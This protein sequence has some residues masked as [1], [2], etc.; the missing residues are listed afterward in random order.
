MSKVSVSRFIA[1]CA[2]LAACADTNPTVTAPGARAALDEAAADGIGFI[3]DGPLDVVFGAEAAATQMAASVQAATGG[4]AS[5]HV[6]FNSGLPI[7]I[8]S[9]QYSFTALG[10]DAAPLT[11]KGAFEVML[12]L[13][14][15]R[16]NKIHGDVICMNIVGN[17]AR[18][19][20][21]IN[22][23]W[24][25]GVQFPIT[26]ATHSFWTV[27][28]NGEGQGADF[29]SPMLFTNA[30]NAQF[31]C[32]TGWTPPAFAIQQGNVQVQP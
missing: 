21:I 12:T 3:N 5:G 9:E 11:A 2:V 29:A 16:Q 31:H 8:A 25:N 1:L 32:T 24:V 19:A 10:T 6:G 15:G 18:V 4:R 30:A 17:T 7:G 28:D 20:A 26:G 23:V 22:K 14:N 27:T 13:A